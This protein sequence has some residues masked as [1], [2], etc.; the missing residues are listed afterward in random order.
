MK[1]CLTKTA[2]DFKK[3]NGGANPFFGFQKKIINW[4]DT[5][6]YNVNEKQNRIEA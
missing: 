3:E 4:A 2:S 1:K 6:M 5:I